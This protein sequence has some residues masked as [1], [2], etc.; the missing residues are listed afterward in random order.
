ME[1]ASTVF[2]MITLANGDV[3]GELTLRTMALPSRAI[4]HPRLDDS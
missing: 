1:I 2:A 4:M 3:S